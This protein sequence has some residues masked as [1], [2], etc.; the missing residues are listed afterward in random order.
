MYF[1]IHLHIHSL[2]LTFLNFSKHFMNACHVQGSRLDRTG[3]CEVHSPT[4]V[5]TMDGVNS[6]VNPVDL[7]N[8]Q[9]RTFARSSTF[10]QNMDYFVD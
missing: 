4:G 5:N 8:H 9:N 10:K 7:G 6:V 3:F 1:F 2:L